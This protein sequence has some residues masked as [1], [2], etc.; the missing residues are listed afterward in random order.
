MSANRRVSEHHE[1]EKWTSQH[2]IALLLLVSAFAIAGAFSTDE[3]PFS[4][5]WSGAYFGLALGLSMF[6]FGAI[7]LRQGRIKGRRRYY[8]RDE[9]PGM[10][11][12]LMVFKIGL[13]TICGVLIGIFHAFLYAP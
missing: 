6:I 2:W 3:D 1:V 10:F 9:H 13:P 12:F 7:N 5:Q 8:R 11:V 4:R